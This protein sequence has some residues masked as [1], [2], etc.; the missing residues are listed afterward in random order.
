METM[1][2]FIHNSYLMFQVFKEFEG[3]TSGKYYKLIDIGGNG[4]E[5]TPYT[6]MNDSG[7]PVVFE[8]EYTFRDLFYDPEHYRVETVDTCPECGGTILGDGYTTVYHCENVDFDHTEYEPDAGTIVCEHSPTYEEKRTHAFSVLDQY[9][10]MQTAF[11]AYAKSFR[12]DEFLIQGSFDTG[13]Y[14]E[15]LDGVLWQLVDEAVLYEFPNRLKF[16]SLMS[17]M[18]NTR[19]HSIAVIQTLRKDLHVY[20]QYVIKQ[21][22]EKLTGE[23]A[24]VAQII[25]KEYQSET[26]PEETCQETESLG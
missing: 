5:G 7:E 15:T 13:Y 23:I 21:H 3:F 6:I 20:L 4:I 12:V 9:I 10:A 17:E 22:A 25:K 24:N 19:P 2:E 26:N 1:Q 11:E 14:L 18:N 16:F 8:D